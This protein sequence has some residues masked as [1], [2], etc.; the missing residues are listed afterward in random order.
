MRYLYKNVLTSVEPQDTTNSPPF[1]AFFYADIY[2]SA[3]PSDRP[4]SIDLR[5]KIKSLYGKVDLSGYAVLPKKKYISQINTGDD[6]TYYALDVV[7]D[8]FEELSEYYGKLKSRGKLSSNSVALAT[9]SPMRAWRDASVDYSHHMSGLVE[10]FN[11]AHH[12]SQEITNYMS[13]E[14]LLAGYFSQ[15]MT[16]SIPVTFSEFSLSNISSPFHTGLAIDI[17]LED[18]ANDEVK[19]A[20]FIQ[21]PN[22][23]VYRNVAKRFGFKVD[24]HIPWRLYFDLNSPY[25]V[26]KLKRQ[27]V[28]SLKEFFS[29]YYY[30]ISEVE[31]DSLQAILS[32]AYSNFH[33]VSPSYTVPTLCSSGL[34]T[35]PVLKVRPPIES[36]ESYR[37]EYDT[38]HFLHLY[39]FLRASE[40]S[41]KWTQREF[42]RFARTAQDVLRFKGL[43]RALKYAESSFTDRTDS[44]FFQRPQVRSNDFN[45][46]VVQA[47]STRRF[48]Y[49]Q[50]S[51]TNT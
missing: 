8:C 47:Y 48:Q 36:V 6:E 39:V 13:Y 3:Y 40:L 41:K 20:G 24:K 25:V 15:I 16:L 33:D 27:G 1:E 19:Y 45:K 46:S 35:V 34:G 9:L 4:H 51:K 2:D 38:A 22:F 43:K 31:L 28:N 12:D 21:D 10:S 18:A 7:K 37:K 11:V 32:P 49:R 14:S 30:R 23:E 42:D 17:A 50:K 5:A 29:K 44:L 26:E